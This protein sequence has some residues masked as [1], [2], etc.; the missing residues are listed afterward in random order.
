MVDLEDLIK[1]IELKRD[2]YYK[3]IEHVILDLIEYVRELINKKIIEKKVILTH[4]YGYPRKGYSI[5]YKMETDGHIYKSTRY[6][7]YNRKD[8]I[9]VKDNEFIKW[10]T[11]DDI[12]MKTY[13]KLI[14]LSDF[15]EHVR[16][17]LNKN[18]GVINGNNK[19]Y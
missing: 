4:V 3:L 14:K 17:L 1:D 13:N 6:K 10:C 7:L 2:N 16:F 18:R 11:T 19:H 15:S 9:K 5:V 8:P 12:E